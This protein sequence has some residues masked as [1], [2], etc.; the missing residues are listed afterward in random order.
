MRIYVGV[1]QRAASVAQRKP[2][3]EITRVARRTGEATVGYVRH[4][5]R[6]TQRQY[7]DAAFESKPSPRFYDYYS[8]SVPSD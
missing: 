2:F 4:A 1:I 8:F 5:T 7:A 6:D 3:I